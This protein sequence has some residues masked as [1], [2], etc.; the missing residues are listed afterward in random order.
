LPPK[1]VYGVRTVAHLLFASVTYA[2]FAARGVS[3]VARDD[4]RRDSV[5]SSRTPRRNAGV[6]AASQR[7]VS[8]VRYE[9]TRWSRLTRSNGSPETVAS[10]RARAAVQTSAARTRKSRQR[11]IWKLSHLCK[12][13]EP[14]SAPAGGGSSKRA[15][16]SSVVTARQKRRPMSGVCR[17]R[18]IGPR[19]FHTVWAERAVRCSRTLLEVVQPLLDPLDWRR[20]AALF[21]AP[22]QRLDFV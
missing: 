1:Q 4:S 16:A 2:C 10:R 12:E 3:V 11:G 8:E 15:S 7:G 14:P 13:F 19:R 21:A 18:R 5:G 6:R 17:S 20:P 22:A 9:R